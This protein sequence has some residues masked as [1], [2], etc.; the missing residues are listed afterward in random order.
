[1]KYKHLFF[2][3]DHT[4]WDFN[5]NARLTLHEL[6]YEL[7]LKKA[8]INNLF[9]ERYFTRRAGGFKVLWLAPI[10]THSFLKL[11]TGLA[12]A[13]FRDSQLTVANAITMAA[14][15]DRARIRMLMSVR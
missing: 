10:N 5:E 9:D 6:Y 1:M 11:F 3:L 8:G 13:A 14:S 12:S 2:D 4:L 15:P 7:D